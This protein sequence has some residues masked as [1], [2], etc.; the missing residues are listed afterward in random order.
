MVNLREI[1][2]IVTHYLRRKEPHDYST[3]GAIRVWGAQLTARTAEGF[4]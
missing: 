4:A 1:A 2:R 3:C